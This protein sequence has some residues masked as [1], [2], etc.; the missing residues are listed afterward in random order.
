MSVVNFLEC[1]VKEKNKMKERKKIRKV[2]FSRFV[3]PHQL[4]LTTITRAVLFRAG[5]RQRGANRC[6]TSSVC[7]ANGAGGDSLPLSSV[8]VST[9]ATRV[10]R[11]CRRCVVP[12]R[13]VALRVVWCASVLVVVLESVVV[14]ASALVHACTTHTCA[15][16]VSARNE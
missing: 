5:R 12:C 9:R 3:P 1:E 7:A 16:T 10:D 2:T 13:V 4:Q 14:G 15:A 8:G 6:F 11:V